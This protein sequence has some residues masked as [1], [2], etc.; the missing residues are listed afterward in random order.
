MVQFPEAI[1]PTFHDFWHIQR[2]KWKWAG[3]CVSSAQHSLQPQRSFP[4]VSH[5]KPGTN[6]S[7]SREGRRVH[8]FVWEGCGR[9]RVFLPGPCCAQRPFW[10]LLQC[11]KLAVRVGQRFLRGWILMVHSDGEGKGIWSEFCVIIS[12]PYT[13]EP[14]TVISSCAQ[15]TYLWTGRVLQ[16]AAVVVC[17]AVRAPC[18][19]EFWA[20]PK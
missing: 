20:L 1:S 11:P 16:Q 15:G 18:Q 2:S 9:P 14:H 4:R 19:E 5:L 6:T 12:L 7:K 3:P 8:L 17:S 13:L 10:L